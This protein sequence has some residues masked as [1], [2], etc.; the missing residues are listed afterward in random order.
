MA[1]PV[2][3]MLIEVGH[4]IFCFFFFFLFLFISCFIILLC[5]FIVYIFVIIYFIFYLPKSYHIRLELN[6][7]CVEK[8]VQT[9]GQISSDCDKN[10]NKDERALFRLNFSLDG[11]DRLYSL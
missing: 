11:Y 2:V 9:E 4:S 7:N 5:E 8:K 6:L 3:Q 1:D 10:E